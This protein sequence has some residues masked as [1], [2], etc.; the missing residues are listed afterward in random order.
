[1]TTRAPAVLKNNSRSTLLLY[2]HILQDPK[3]LMKLRHLKKAASG[4]EYD[5]LLIML[6]LKVNSHCCMVGVYNSSGPPKAKTSGRNSQRRGPSNNLL[7]TTV[8]IND[9]CK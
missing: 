8:I 1:M 9:K 6:A 4:D 3:F 5:I 7:L 2:V